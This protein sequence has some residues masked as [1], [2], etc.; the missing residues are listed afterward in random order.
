MSEVAIFFFF[1][2]GMLAPR[3]KRTSDGDIAKSACM[4]EGEKLKKLE[5]IDCYITCCIM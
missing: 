3:M 1:S 4:E 5:K 2:I